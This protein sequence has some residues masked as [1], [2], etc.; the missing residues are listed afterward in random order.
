MPKPSPE[1]C[2][3]KQFQPTSNP[4]T[5][6]QQTTHRRQ[7]PTLENATQHPTPQTINLKAQPT[8]ASTTPSPTKTQQSPHL[9]CTLPKTKHPGPCLM[10]SNITLQEP[11]ATIRT[12]LMG[13][14][15]GATATQGFSEA[16]KRHI[17]GQSTYTNIIS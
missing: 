5:H 10:Y 7:H 16:Q 17:I 8:H 13:L 9:P 14:Q 4:H 6:H 12:L 11:N 1:R 15:R 3:I 2:D